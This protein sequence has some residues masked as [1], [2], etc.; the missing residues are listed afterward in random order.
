LSKE[1]V[2]KPT[3]SKSELDDFLSSLKGVTYLNIDPKLVSGKHFKTIF[4][5][6]EADVLICKTIDDLK[7]AELSGRVSGYFK[8]VLSNDDITEIAQAAESG[9][10]I[11][12]VEAFDWK[13][14][15]LENIIAKLHKS[16]TKIYATAKNA[17]EVRIMFGVLE[18]GVDG[19]IL[20]TNNVNEVNQS[21]Q[22]LENMVFPIETAKIIDIKD[23]G[24]GERVCVDTVSM[25]RTGEGML[26]GS[27]SNFM[28]LVHN[29]SVGSSF[30]SP[31][32]FRVNAGAVYCYTITPD[33]NTKYLS[34][35]ESGTEILIVNKEGTSRR[36]TVGRA[37]IETRP[38]RLIRAEIGNEIGT[39]IL[40]NA[41]TIRF[42]TDNGNLIPVT[43][44]KLG[45][46]VIAYTKM[47]S[48]RHFGLEVKEFI[49]EK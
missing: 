37:K 48:G 11:V 5:S 10:E 38:L 39:V 31:R 30:T 6:E 41:E 24:M 9:S 19:V 16:R 34:E 45:D 27:R 43:E 47:P 26:I 28:F 46:E 7:K 17:N 14:I 4:E 8:K 49:V 18:L 22:Y 21:R 42:I 3:V 1:L 40:Q 15:P 35:I 44:L 29:E 32:P 36:A 12:V 20:S 33:G 23:V 2:I 25:L 13:I